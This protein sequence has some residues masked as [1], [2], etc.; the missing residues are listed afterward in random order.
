MRGDEEV[1]AKTLLVLRG[2]GRASSE[3]DREQ[4]R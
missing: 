4:W 1:S 3:G 2:T